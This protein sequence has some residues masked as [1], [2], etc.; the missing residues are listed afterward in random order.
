MLEVEKSTIDMAGS[1]R[2]DQIRASMGEIGPTAETPAVE[3]APSGGDTAE[4]QNTP[5]QQTS[6]PS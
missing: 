1:A 4:P 5:Q 2:L 3:A 6:E